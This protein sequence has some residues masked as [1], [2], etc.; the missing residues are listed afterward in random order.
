MRQHGE[1]KLSLEVHIQFFLQ[2]LRIALSR[3]SRLGPLLFVIAILISVLLWLPRAWALRAMYVDATLRSQVRTALTTVASREGWLLSD[4]ELLSVS[5][6][7]LAI[8]HHDHLRVPTPS[9]DCT[10]TLPSNTLAC[11]A[12][13]R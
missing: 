13:S 6:G 12:S 11:G 4:I 9:T 7:A 2:V 10:V 1:S 3:A 8:R 5:H